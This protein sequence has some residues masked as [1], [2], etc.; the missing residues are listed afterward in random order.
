MPF[1]ASLFALML[2]ALTASAAELKTLKGEVVT[3]DVVSVGPKEVVLDVAGVKKAFA[4]S[5]IAGIDYTKSPK[6]PADAKWSDLELVDGTV[7]RCSSFALKKTTVTVKLLGSD[8]EVKMPLDA[9]ANVLHQA[10][11]SG[12]RKAWDARTA[13]KRINDA[14]AVENGGVI[15]A[16]DCTILGADEA[17]E[18]LTF[19]IKGSTQNLTRP[20]KSFAGLLFQRGLNEKS[21]PVVCKLTD[22][23]HCNLMV[24][25][26]ESKNGELHVQTSS[27]VT[28]VYKPAQLVRLDYSSANLAYLSDLTPSKVTETSTDDRVEHYRKDHNLDDRPLRLLGVVYAKGLALHSTTDLE[29]KLKGEYRT[30]QGVAGIDDQVGGHNRPVVLR[31]YADDGVGLPKVILERTFT[32][33]NPKDRVAPIS[34]NI[35]DV[36]TLRIVVTHTEDDLLDLGLHLDLADFRV[37]K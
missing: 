16:I 35:K 29:F 15:N 24:S 20:L 26:I 12:R 22:I 33:K 25:G 14:V 11:D 27:G 7:L 5:L 4:V 9:V 3:G 1:R 34:L 6:I 36:Q 28:V 8:I 23:G 10:Q 18:N 37:I 32:R 30:L 21:P 13:K 19:K 17:G 2:F 31:I